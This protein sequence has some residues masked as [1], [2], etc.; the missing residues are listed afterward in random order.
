MKRPGLFLRIRR[1]SL[2]GVLF[3]MVLSVLPVLL[4]RVVEP[5]GSSVMLQRWW[6]EGLA[7]SYRW[8]SLDAM[9]PKLALAVI[10]AEDQRFPDHWGF[11]AV[12]MRAA[13]ADH[14]EGRPL[15]GASTI[16]QQVAR[17][18]FLWQG[19]GFF[20][21]VLEA[22][23]TLLIEALW[24]KQR[25]LEVYLNIAETGERMF[26]F[27]VAAERYFGQSVS[28]LGTR[29]SALLA[30]VLPN[31]VVYRVDRPSA[32]VLR[33]RDWVITQMNNLGGVGFLDSL[34][35]GPPP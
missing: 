20:R 33:R 30:A 13:L 17:N 12:Q 26:G 8:V 15:R 18:L 2:L 11:D 6:S 31:P 10:A 5:P 22:W 27:A 24:S 25:I 14:F 29:R 7:Q 3:A 4:F 35:A 34:S 1:W 16:S 19:G 9:D 32:Y 21:K 28:S 23:F